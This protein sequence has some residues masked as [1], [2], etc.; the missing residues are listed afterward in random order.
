MDYPDSPKGEF[1]DRESKAPSTVP[2]G[3]QPVLASHQV[4]EGAAFSATW[5]KRS[6]RCR[7]SLNVV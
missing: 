5:M 2:W 3:E 6:M 4:R 7:I 1:E